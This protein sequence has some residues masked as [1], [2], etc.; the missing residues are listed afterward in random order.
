MAVGLNTV[1]EFGLGNI[2]YKQVVLKTT[3][4]P[5]VLN[6]AKCL[7]ILQ[8]FDGILT[9]IGISRFGSDI[10]GNPFLRNLIENF[11]H[12]PVLASIK[13]IAVFFV[14]VLAVNSKYVPW[15]SSA[16]RAICYM[17]FFTAIVP[18]IYILFVNV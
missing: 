8:I 17:Y 16:L 7:V 6:L 15:I 5:Q 2:A 10:E 18:W 13:I 3:I 9:S 14:F 4:N 11:G 1:E 12:I